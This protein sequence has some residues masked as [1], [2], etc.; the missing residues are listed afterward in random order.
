V[1]ACA[2]GVVHV[3]T[4]CE[5]LPRTYDTLRRGT[6]DEDEAPTFT[7][8]FERAVVGEDWHPTGDGVR[9]Q[10]GALVVEGLRNHPVWLKRPLP[11]AYRVEFTAWTDGD[12]GDIKV[13]LSGDGVSAAT[14]VNYVSSGYVVV[15]GGWNNRVS[16]IAR[17][18][19][20]GRDRLEVDAPKVEPGRR[21]RFSITRAGGELTWALDGSELARFDDPQPLAGPQHRHFAFGGWEAEVFF[22]D[23]RIYDLGGDTGS[24]APVAD[25]GARP[26][27]AGASPTPP[28][29]EAVSP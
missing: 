3:V 13:E 7:D 2:I 17:L 5:E 14:S 15:F 26:L 21:Y 24:E 11:E 8:D 1:I 25:G 12:D 27:A 9:V 19:E 18:D 28:P 6:G 29:S 22:D 4:G 10:A 20:H 23:L 16:V